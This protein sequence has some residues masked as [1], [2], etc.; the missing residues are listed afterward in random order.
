MHSKNG[1]GSRAAWARGIAAVWAVLAAAAGGGA[2]AAPTETVLYSF[3]GGPSDGSGPQAGLIADSSGNLY[4]TT[5]SGGPV[6]AGVV[7]KL[8]SSGTETVLYRFIGFSSDGANPFAGLIADSSG[9]FYGTTQ[10]GGGLNAAG[11]V[12]KLSPG[13][14]ETVLYTFTIGA[15]G[16]NPRAGLIADSSGNLYGTTFQGGA[17]ASTS[18]YEITCGVVFKLSPGGTYTLLQTFGGG[19]GGNPYAGSL[20]AD[21]SGNL[22]GTTEFG[23]LGCST[24]IEGATACGPGT[25]FKLTPG[26]T[27]TVLYI[28]TGGSDGANPFAG[29][30][31]DSSGNL[32]GTTCCGGAS[33]NGVVFKLTPGGTE[34]VLHSFT[35]VPSDG[36][37]PFAGLIA[38]SAGNLYGTTAFGGAS[39][40]GVV[41]KLSPGGTE[42][43][44]Y[45]FTGGSDGGTPYAGRYADSTGNLY[46][47]TQVGGASGNGVVFKLTGTGF[48]TGTPFLGSTA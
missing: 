11:T 38:D 27:E 24:S 8:S 34:T 40:S 10:N 5:Y 48:V 4:G 39:N 32:Y 6:G 45:I 33:R 41:F 22:Y 16:F 29:L 18:C 31:A 13:G 7:F 9:N 15:D 42:T 47:T 21:S 28:F 25:V 12:F 23:G 36:A 14:T 44:L 20:I 26:G 35:G 30:I 3:N 17:G 37:S 46:G 43:V 2:L 19:N 1:H